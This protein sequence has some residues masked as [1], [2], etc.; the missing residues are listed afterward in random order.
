MEFVST[1]LSQI[2][3]LYKSHKTASSRIGQYKVAHF[4]KY[5]YNTNTDSYRGFAAQLSRMHG[6]YGHYFF[7]PFFCDGLEI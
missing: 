3:N 5:F 7:L 2:Q 4:N 1:V 6:P